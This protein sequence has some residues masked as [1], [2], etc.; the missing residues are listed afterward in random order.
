MTYIYGF[1][2]KWWVKKLKN[3]LSLWECYENKECLIWDIK[4]I[5]LLKEIKIQS[6]YIWSDYISFR[7]NHDIYSEDDLLFKE[8]SQDNFLYYSK[9]FYI[10]KNELDEIDW[11]RAHV[12][13]RKFN[14]NWWVINWCYF[15]WTLPF[16]INW[17]SWYKIN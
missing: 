15:C 8:Y 13:F 3:W 9:W 2:F 5:D 14:D 4:L 1:S 11:N 17:D 16:Y 6:I 12:V 10:D 7:T